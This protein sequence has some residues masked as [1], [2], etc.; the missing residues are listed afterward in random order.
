M[1]KKKT[2]NELKDLEKKIGKVPKFFKEL[3]EKEPQMYELVMRMEGHIWDD[4][5]LTRKT[6]KL[7]AIAIAAALRDQHADFINAGNIA[8][9]F[10]HDILFPQCQAGVR[11]VAITPDRHHRGGK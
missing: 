8:I 4:G 6:K 9:L 7:I 5:A 10:Q 1:V 3:T 2:E 11:K